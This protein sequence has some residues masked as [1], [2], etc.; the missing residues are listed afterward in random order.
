MP[1]D[2]LQTLSD[3]VATPSVNPMGRAVSGPEFFEHQ[4][5]AY[6]EQLFARFKIPTWRQPI[7]EKRDNLLARVDGDP[8]VQEGGALLLLEAHQDTV[9]TDGMSIAPFDPQQREGR[10]YGRGA[11]DIKGGMAS[12]LACLVR[13]AEELPTPRPT[14]VMACT[15]NEE[16][17][18]TGATGLCRL[19]SGQPNPIISRRPDAAIVAEPTNLNV[20]VAHKGMVRWRC[21][22]H[23]R[24]AHSSQP[25]QGENAI[26]R[27]AQVLAALERYQH[28]V[29]G[30]LAEHARCGRPTLSVGTIAGGISV[31]T[32]PDKCTIEIDRRLVPGE[33][34]QQAWQHVVDYVAAETALGRHVEHDPPFMQSSGLNDAHNA[35]LAQRLVAAVQDATGRAPQVLGVPFGTD[36]FCYDA[37]GVPSVVFG[38]GSILQA[39]TADEWVPLA[40]VEQA[41]EV[42]YRVIAQWV[43]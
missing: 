34:P 40:E 23:G 15:V 17:G 26:F 11:C 25:Q 41:A 43:K 21:R 8:P 7:A 3:L 37:A 32:V 5:T 10:L 18:F 6:L 42:L 14:V 27:M 12:M 38:P 20:V 1:L 2:L 19:W 33:Q 39:H 35:P 22:T 13:L 31:N 36:A 9:P 29:V 4:L 16:H 30:A 28:S 24:A